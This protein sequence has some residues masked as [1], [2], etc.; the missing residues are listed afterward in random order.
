MLRPLGLVKAGRMFICV[1]PGTIFSFPACLLW[2]LY[3]EALSVSSFKAP[4]YSRPLLLRP[5]AR[6]QKVSNWSS[7]LKSGMFHFSLFL[8]CS[9]MSVLLTQSFKSK[10]DCAFK[11]LKSEIYRL[12]SDRFPIGSSLLAA[13]TPFWYRTAFAGHPRWNVSPTAVTRFW[14]LQYW[15]T[16]SMQCYHLRV[17]RAYIDSMR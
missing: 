17:Y 12:I 15:Y 8:S 1:S 16:R 9:A 4:P 13:S 7:L 3:S 2:I 5:T 10:L 14:L 11:F 6:F